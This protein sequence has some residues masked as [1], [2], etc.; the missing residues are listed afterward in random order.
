MGPTWTFRKKIGTGFAAT[1]I[2]LVLIAAIAVYT[3]QTVVESKDLVITTNAQ[4]LISVERLSALIERKSSATRGFLFSRDDKYLEFAN[5]VRAELLGI[6]ERLKGQVITEEGRRSVEQIERAEADHHAV[7]EKVI[8]LRKSDP[9]LDASV[10]MFDEQ[11]APKRAFLNQQLQA[12]VQREEKMLEEGK[13]AASDTAT[14]SIKFVVIITVVATVLSICLA[15]FLTTSLSR[16][17]SSAVQHVQS[18]SSELQAAANQQAT[19]A[20]EQATAMNEITTTISE[21]LATSR[22]IA[23]SAQRVA[24][25][26]DQT[27]SGASSGDHT[28]QKSLESVSGIRRQVDLIVNHMLDLGKKSQQ[29]GGIL[30]IINELTEQTNILAINAT[31]EASGAGDAGKRFTV[32][33]DEIRKLADRVG[34]STKEIRGLIDEIR[35]AVN[36]TVM[37]TEGGSKA[38]DIGMRQ[39]NEVATAFKQI[40]SLVGTTTEAAREIELSTKQ[41]ATAVEQVN[42]AVSNVAQATKETEASS[43][44]TYQT[45][46]QLTSLSRDLARLI[47]P[48]GA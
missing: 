9:N 30:E 18:S 42:L 43:C 39:F 1:V 10:R 45:A 24:Q 36:S 27:A 2:L 37:A 32:V 16:Q 5:T 33:A 47:Q 41:Q 25:I 22:Q 12:F 44:Q 3:L 31:I 29:I 28:V 40:N 17:I 8:A 21:L 6:L 48:A 23:E 38:V 7:L 26:A 19:S 34:G 14:T 20:K 11:L 15:F 4:N 13:R 35:A 46:S